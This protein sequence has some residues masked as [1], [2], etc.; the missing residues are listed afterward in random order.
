VTTVGKTGEVNPW[1]RCGDS[2][3]IV[4]VNKGLC[5]IVRCIVSLP[6]DCGV[7]ILRYRDPELTIGVAV[8]VLPSVT[9]PLNKTSATSINPKARPIL[10]P[11]LLRLELGGNLATQY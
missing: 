6:R 11:I 8:A 3:G 4:K 5:N 9:E 10:S 1:D 2:V 7:V